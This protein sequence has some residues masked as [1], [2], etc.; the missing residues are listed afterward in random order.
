MTSHL[1]DNLI[2]T[3]A[4]NLF[5]LVV[6]ARSVVWICAAVAGILWYQRCLND[7][8]RECLALMRDDAERHTNQ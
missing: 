7:L 2:N 4:M 8:T 1:M 3:P 5:I 6:E